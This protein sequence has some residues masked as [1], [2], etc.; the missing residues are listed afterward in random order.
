ME[1]FFRRQVIKSSAVAGALLAAGIIS[2][3]ITFA[4]EGDPSKPTVFS[5]F[6]MHDTPNIGGSLNPQLAISDIQ[7][8]GANFILTLEPNNDQLALAYKYQVPV[9]TRLFLPD[10]RTNIDHIDQVLEGVSKYIP[11][12]VII[13]FNEVNL[14]SETG[15]EKISPGGH[16]KEDFIP[17]AEQ[18]ISWGAIPAITPAAQRADSLSFTGEML[19]EL[20]RQKKGT[21][22][23]ENLVFSLH[24]YTFYPQQSPILRIQSYDQLVKDRLGF[25]L[26]IYITEGGLYQTA[27]NY[28]SEEEVAYSTL[29]LLN[30]TL[31]TGP[32]IETYCL[33]VLAN[34]AQR[35]AIED[36]ENQS[37]LDDFEVAAWRVKDRVR[38][39]Y[40]AV[41]SL[42]DSFI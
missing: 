26:P 5:I 1:R 9:L 41:S 21:W 28:F 38:L 6:G 11:D 29:N 8:L 42:A 34:M 14:V 15:G 32:K 24:N 3:R 20:K 2:P 18:I 10:N 36:H 12:P 23:K 19:D 37:E 7:A 27:E 39:V 40:Q 22:I 33:W 35:P 13:P 31:P 25:S 17:S 30:L 4:G 16:I